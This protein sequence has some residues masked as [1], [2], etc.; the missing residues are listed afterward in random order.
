MMGNKQVEIVTSKNIQRAAFS[1]NSDAALIAA[2]G[3]GIKNKIVAISM[4]NN[5]TTEA[6]DEIIYLRDGSGGTILYGDA[7]GGIYLPGRGGVFQLLM[8]GE[9]VIE[10]YFETSAN[11]AFYMDLTNGR[12]IA[13]CVWYY[14]EA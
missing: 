12:E 2:A 5:E 7:S 14:Q 4:H 6:N 10:P 3:A 1:T 11:T 9:G 8:S 13:G